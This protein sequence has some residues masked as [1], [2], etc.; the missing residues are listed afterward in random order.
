MRV[1]LG[2]LATAVLSTVVTGAQEL[3][4]FPNG[5]GHPEVQT[6]GRGNVPRHLPS[7]GATSTANTTGNGIV[8]HSGPVMLGRAH[9]YY[10]WYGN[11]ATLDP[12]GPAI[13]NEL[14]D[15]IGG[16]LY[17]NINTTYFDGSSRSVSNSVLR[18][19]SI[20][21]RLANSPTSLTDS[22][23][24]TIVQNAIVDGLGADPNGIYFVLTAPG[25]TETSGFLTQYCGWHTYGTYN[26]TA[27]KYAFVGNATG[28]NLGNCAWQIGSSPNN[29]PAVD[30]MASVV[31]H[32]LEETVT[33]PQLNA[34]YDN[35][36]AEN[37]DKCAWTFGTTRTTSNGSLTNIH[38]GTRDYLI[39][40]N[41]VNASGGYCAMAYA[42]APDFS[43]TLTPS[44]RSFGRSR[45]NHRKLCRHSEPIEWL[46]RFCHFD[47]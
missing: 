12:T 18:A 27:I 28:P 4:P 38:L 40:R 19:G 23:I 21:G 24:W 7:R 20:T 26:G 13:L 17:F 41:W 11:W 5:S 36:G 47:R 2:F 29:D 42:L 8:Y 46:L 1:K 34:W 32:E 16:S 9:V 31:I 14:A 3:N 35:S 22:N 15:N 6:D 10:I 45:W 30:G 44:S 43:L 33:D 37:A 25:I 39:Q